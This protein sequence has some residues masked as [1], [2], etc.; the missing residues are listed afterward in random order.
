MNGYP[1]AGAVANSKV[2]VSDVGNYD[3][4]LS[5]DVSPEYFSYQV[6]VIPAGGSAVDHTIDV[7]HAPTYLVTKGNTVAVLTSFYSSAY[8]DLTG[9]LFT[10]ESTASPEI[11]N[12]K[13]NGGA[14][15]NGD[16]ISGSPI[17]TA[18]L[19]DNSAVWDA[20]VF[21]NGDKK[22]ATFAPLLPANH[23][24]KLTS[25]IGTLLSSPETNSITI[26]AT[27]GE[28]VATWE[29]FGLIASGG[30]KAD[31]IG[32]AAAYPSPFKPMS[33][34]ADKNTL[35][36]AYN[37]TADGSITIMIVDI[38]GRTV[39]NK[40]CSSGTMGGRAGYNEVRWEGRMVG[41]GVI[42]NGI[43][44]YKI[45]SG[46]KILTSGKIIVFD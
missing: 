19:T 17:L 27:D 35:R 5:Y 46:K 4:S 36:I 43:Y 23:L 13:I 12:V 44:P 1:I 8:S 37:L 6:K 9:M 20:S 29:V 21:V 33:G 26:E 41:G 25:S 10:F 34:D 45:M 38:S 39:F 2:Y 16:F 40:K 15:H 3:P 42:G 22:A 24:S 14:V 32:G 18:D 31:I 28:W 11:T 30:G 7:G